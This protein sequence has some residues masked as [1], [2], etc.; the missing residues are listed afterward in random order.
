MTD[1]ARTD[2]R[3]RQADALAEGLQRAAG[4]K[5][6]VFLGAAP[7]VGKTCAMLARAHE[8][9]QAGTDL[10]VGLV[11]THGRADTVAQLEGLPQ[12]PRT[13]L[14]HRGHALEELDLDAALQRRPAVL[15]VDELAHRNAPGSR[16]QHRWQDVL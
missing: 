13:T 3:Q 1:A 4:G 8:Q 16:H 7:G 14:H 12:L 2:K 15:L 11:E 10:L 6:T 9:R 5:L